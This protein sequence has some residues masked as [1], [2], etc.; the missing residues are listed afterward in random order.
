MATRVQKVSYCALMVPNRAGQGALVLS[1]LSSAGVNLLAYSWFPERGKAQLDL[2]PEKMSE[3][4]KVARR[5]GW[6]LGEVKKA[7]VVQGD[8]R[9]GAV[10][11]LTQKLADQKINIT[12]AQAI[13]AGKGRFGMI[14]WVRPKDYGKAVRVLRA[15]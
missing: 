8:D 7:F 2:V 13:A 10:Q 12:S 1:A 9:V 15:R 5:E 3:L 11:R 14:L 6:K 4:K